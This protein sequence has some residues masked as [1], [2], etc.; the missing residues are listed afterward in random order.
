MV[1]SASWFVKQGFQGAFSLYPKRFDDRLSLRMTDS[2][3]HLPNRRKPMV[4]FPARIERAHSDRARSA[5]K[6]DVGGGFRLLTPF[7]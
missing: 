3:S 4:S 7:S 6:K 2:S 5:S 1:G